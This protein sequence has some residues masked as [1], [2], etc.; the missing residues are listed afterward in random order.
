MTKIWVGWFEINEEGKEKEPEG[1]C[2][3]KEEA[4]PV[5][6]NNPD[7]NKQQVKRGTIRWQID[8]A[9]FIS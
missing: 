2:T 6:E 5:S 9:F 7:C 1:G 3:I 8:F 4:S